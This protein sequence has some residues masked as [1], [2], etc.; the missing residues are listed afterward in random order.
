MRD[1]VRSFGRLGLRKI[2]AYSRPASRTKAA[3]P[4]IAFRDH[5]RTSAGARFLTDRRFQRRRAQNGPLKT[6]TAPR[7]IRTK[8]TMWF[9]V[10][11]SPSHS[12]EKTANTASVIT[13]CIAFSSA[14]A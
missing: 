7:P 14:G 8:P 3:Q 10:S 4:R 11:F 12:T 6:I 13:S 5:L 1:M 2:G 9:G